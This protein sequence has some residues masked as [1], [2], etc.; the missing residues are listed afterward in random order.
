MKRFFVLLFFLS[1]SSASLHSQEVAPK[2]YYKLWLGF[3]NAYVDGKGNFIYETDEGYTIKGTYDIA[4]RDI[5]SKVYYD[6]KGAKLNGRMTLRTKTVRTDPNDV[7]Y[8]KTGYSPYKKITVAYF[9][10]VDLE[11]VLETTRPYE[12]VTQYEFVDG[13][14]NGKY[15]YYYRVHGGNVDHFHI[16]K[17][18]YLDNE[19]DGVWEDRNILDCSG[20]LHTW[21]EWING[22]KEELTTTT[23]ENGVVTDGPT[24]VRV[25]E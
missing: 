13:V 16:I 17:G 7:P 11:G 12:E 15:Y 19:K 3:L 9:N 21:F 18:R 24:T 1:L 6:D 10:S 14:M 8:A 25:E 2:G 23:Y 5:L 22:S 4:S 20:T